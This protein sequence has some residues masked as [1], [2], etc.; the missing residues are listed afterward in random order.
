[1][2]RKSIP[3]FAALLILCLCAGAMTSCGWFK[4]DDSKKVPAQGAAYEIFTVTPREV[5]NGP[6]GDTLRA[7]LAAPVEAINQKEPLYDL[8]TITPQGFKGMIERHRNLIRLEV[9]AQYPQPEMTVQYDL[10]SAPQIQVNITGPNDSVLAAY[11]SEHRSE[12]QHIFDMTERD[13]YVAYLN[14]Y[15]ERRIEEQIEEKF[16]FKMRIPVGYAIRNNTIDNF[17]WISFEHRHA[18]QGIVIYSYPYT[19]RADFEAE[20]LVARRN[21]FMK[22][23]PGPADGSYMKTGDVLP[24]EV[25]HMRINGRFWAELYGFW[26]VAG[27]FMGGPFRSYS[28]LDTENNRVVCVDEYVYSPR[29]PKRNYLRQ[30]ETLLYTVRFPGDGTA[31]AAAQ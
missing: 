21:E 22:L 19:G 6:L 11:I 24:P 23:I 14:E 28:T 25:R 10:Y 20:A 30:L 15:G 3:G 4:K 13:R 9:G 31:A 2:E 5:W 7:V 16:G 26:D 29:L 27:D 1:M 12:L 17:M 18:S 8:Y